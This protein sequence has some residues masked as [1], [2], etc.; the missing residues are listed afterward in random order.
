MLCD[1]FGVVVP[2]VCVSAVSPSM[3]TGIS[4]EKCS[5]WKTPLLCLFFHS[6]NSLK[7]DNSS[8]L[9]SD[10]LRKSRVRRTW[11]NSFSV[12]L[13]RSH[14]DEERH[15]KWC[16]RE[17]SG[18]GWFAMWSCAA[19][20]YTQ[21]YRYV[22]IKH[23]S[24]RRA[25]PSRRSFVVEFRLIFCLLGK[26]ISKLFCVL[27]PCFMFCYHRRCFGEASLFRVPLDSSRTPKQRNSIKI[28][29]NCNSP[30]GSAGIGADFSA[31]A[32]AS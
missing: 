11:A 32:C 10:E 31:P 15:V 24:Q 6:L 5:R 17:T 23:F 9:A 2:F 13:L 12:F 27:S 1:S 22:L 14:H 30:N 16:S 26:V 3:F 8:A 19:N 18:A 25:K 7:S 21:L 20:A 29:E 28:R 4:T